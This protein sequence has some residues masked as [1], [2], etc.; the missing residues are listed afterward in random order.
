MATRGFVISRESAIHVCSSFP[1]VFL[2]SVFLLSHLCL[3]PSTPRH[4]PSLFHLPS[5][6]YWFLRLWQMMAERCLLW[7]NCPII[8]AVM[9]APLPPAYLFINVMCHLLH[10]QEGEPGRLNNCRAVPH[11]LKGR[12]RRRRSS[13]SGS[14]C[15]VWNT[16]VQSVEW[17]TDFLWN[18]S[19]LPFLQVIP[20]IKAWNGFITILIGDIVLHRLRNRTPNTTLFCVSG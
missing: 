11:R 2:L 17:Q 8:G 20:I 7:D 19:E 18:G 10:A 6:L 13:A 15:G 14:K 16:Y 5:E 9:S 3:P 1:L 4:P 12:R